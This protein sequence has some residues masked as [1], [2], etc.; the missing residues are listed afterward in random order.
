MRGAGANCLAGPP[1]FDCHGVTGRDAIALE[2][3]QFVMPSF[4]QN[5][6]L[7]ID[8]RHWHS[9]LAAVLQFA[10]GGSNGACFYEVHFSRSLCLSIS[11]VI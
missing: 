6:P 1:C 5:V 10:C 4:P 11:Y 7:A 9:A 3:L 2:A 8:R